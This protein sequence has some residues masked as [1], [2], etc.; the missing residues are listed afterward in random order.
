YFGVKPTDLNFP[1]HYAAQAGLEPAYRDKLIKITGEPSF[2]YGTGKKT[3]QS[4][5]GGVIQTPK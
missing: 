2:D 4:K 5:G 1:W 3:Q